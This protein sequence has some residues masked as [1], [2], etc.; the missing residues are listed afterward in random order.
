VVR[1]RAAIRIEAPTPCLGPCA[2]AHSAPARPPAPNAARSAKE[3]KTQLVQSVAPPP[4]RHVSDYRD[5]INT[6]QTEVQALRA[7]LA[8]PPPGAPGSAA[9]A[10]GAGGGGSGG[11]AAQQAHG[12]AP[13]GAAEAAG[14]RA[15]EPDAG[16]G[17]GAGAPAG[18]SAS[19]SGAAGTGA[20]GGDAAAETLAWIDGLASE[21]NENV[22]ERI[23]LQ[24]AL[25][26]LE[27]INVCNAYELHN[28]EALI[29][30]GEGWDCG[31]W[32]QGGRGWAGPREQGAARA[33]TRD[34]P[35]CPTQ[36]RAAAR[37]VLPIGAARALPG[38]PRPEEREE[39]VARAAALREEVAAHEA[40][41]AG[42]R[43]DIEENEAARRSIQGRIDAAMEG[44]SGSGS[45]LKIL[46]T[47]RIQVR[48]CVRGGGGLAG[49]NPRF[50][51][52]PPNHP[53]THPPTP[54]TPGRT[55]AGA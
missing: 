36:R 11:A 52:N 34:R 5:L 18:R 42:Y 21:I 9:A 28:L 37:P 41:A 20:A 27:D 47:F 32:Q 17:A 2:A 48:V 44:L 39:A 3:I 46:S 55:P 38:T 1:P 33:A 25:F 19:V 54:S 29:G 31:G 40:A 26:E 53:P 50:P 8:A 30:G 10:G 16:G 4:E 23:N 12:R 15:S 22:E 45:L 14:R 24:K 6:L 51:P 13:G 7:R 43:S 49:C 35:E